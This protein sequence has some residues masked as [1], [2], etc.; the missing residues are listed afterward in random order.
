[1]PE[2]TSGDE[3][4]GGGTCPSTGRTALRTS[5]LMDAILCS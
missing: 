5:Q 2:A 4:R 3:L 1:L